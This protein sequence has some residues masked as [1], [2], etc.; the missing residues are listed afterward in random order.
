M[1]TEDNDYGCTKFNGVSDMM[2]GPDGVLT[3]QLDKAGISHTQTEL[4]MGTLTANPAYLVHYNSLNS[5]IPI[6]ILVIPQTGVDSWAEEYYH[7]PGMTQEDAQKLDWHTV[8]Q[9]VSS[10]LWQTIRS[11]ITHPTPCPNCGKKDINS[12]DKYTDI[13]GRVRCSYCHAI[14]Q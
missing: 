3:E 13:R 6:T 4:R 8:F 1:Y 9:H 10:V 2:V 14:R 5:K 12:K 11:D 7:F